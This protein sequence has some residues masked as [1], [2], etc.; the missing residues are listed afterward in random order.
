[1]SGFTAVDPDGYN[2]TRKRSVNVQS[3]KLQTRSDEIDLW[4]GDALV[5][6]NIY[7]DLFRNFT[8]GDVTIIDNAGFFEKRPI[9]GDE[10]L[11]IQF[12]TSP[13]FPGPY[14]TKRF[15]IYKCEDFA[16]VLGSRTRTF[17][18]MFATPP[19]QLDLLTRIRFSY[20]GKKESDIVQSIATNL[21]GI[22]SV[23]VETSK[24][25]R[26]FVCAGMRPFQA[27]NYMAATAVRP[28][29]YPA[30]NYTF[31]ET[32][33]GF[34]FCS[35]DKL[36]ETKT[37]KI[38]QFH[39]ARQSTPYN[40]IKIANVK[41]YKIINTFDNFGNSA[42]GMYGAR[43]FVQ[44]L[45]RKVVEE[46]TYNYRSDFGSQVDVDNKGVMLR[47]KFST[48]KDQ[49]VHLEPWQKKYNSEHS[50]DWAKRRMPM[51]QQFYNYKVEC[52]MDGS[53]I[54]DVGDNIEFRLVSNVSESQEMDQRLSGQ[55]LVT[56]IRHMIDYK[57]H[58]M[59][60]EIRKN[61]LKS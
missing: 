20:R 60:L 1:M 59:V 29:R 17:K 21:L 34:R 9:C 18:L 30:S 2:Y 19:A 44:D 31:H 25:S 33:T 27:I 43:V 16:S 32:S 57:E 50:E 41:D 22:G 35:L 24:Y 47:E 8:T 7:E 11:I 56:A 26:E 15:E 55:Y 61:C 28:G 51:M 3:L 45:V 14:Y 36:M 12:K 49:L 13:E 40:D 6:L 42:G 46:R 37:G 23:D 5:S 38:L 54:F 52:E 48:A 10:K 58:K 39:V 4:N 53:M